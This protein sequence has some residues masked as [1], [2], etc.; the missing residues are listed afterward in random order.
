[1]AT[2][3]VR[4]KV[5]IQN[6]AGTKWL[7]AGSIVELDKAD[8]LK[9]IANEQATALDT[10]SALPSE[11]P[12][13]PAETTKTEAIAELMQVKGVSEKNANALYDA[14]YTSITALQ[15]VTAAQL[16]ELEGITPRVAQMIVRDAAEFE[17]E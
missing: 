17:A 13:A 4:V 1:M 9:L 12:S 16:K 3:K 2:M 10:N 11:A 5:S 15:K 14:G 7:P 8:A 6:G